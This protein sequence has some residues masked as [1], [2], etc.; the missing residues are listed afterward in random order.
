MKQ[1]AFRFCEGS[2]QNSLHCCTLTAQANTGRRLGYHAVNANVG[3]T[4]E[5][6][7]ESTIGALA[8][9]TTSTA[10]DIGVVVSLTEANA[11]LTK[12]LEDNSNELWELKAL[13]KKEIT[14]VTGKRSLLHLWDRLLPQAELTLN[15]LRAS[16]QNHGMVDYNKTAF[17]PP[18]CKI[19]AHQKPAKRRTWAPHFQH[20]YSL[21]REMH[22][23]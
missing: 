17:A 4:E 21:G 16:R 10:V 20:R 14:E 18:E 12:Q 8:N 9:L 6:M 15:L 13:L 3:Q 19:I 1:I 11:H 22:H 2:I 5:Q 23:Y 7:S